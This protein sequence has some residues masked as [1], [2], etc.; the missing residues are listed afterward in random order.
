MVTEEQ[1]L[2]ALRD[3]ED[4][5]I[6]KSIVELD[7]VKDLKVEDGKVSVTVL[8]TIANC[9]LRNTIEHSVR[10]ALANL[11]GV[12]EIDLTIET[13]TD[14]QRAKFAEKLRGESRRRANRRFWTWMIASCFSLWL[15]A[16]GASVN[17]R[18]RPTWL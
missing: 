12:S 18:S 4:P 3:V 2:E 10:E 17:P 16:K 15:P 14:E 13:M 7:M 6:H 11:S 8:V 1:V 5:E 9:P